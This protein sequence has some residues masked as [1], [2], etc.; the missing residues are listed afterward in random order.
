M[1]ALF[2]TAFSCSRQQKKQCTVS[3]SIFSYLIWESGTSLLLPEKCP[4]RARSVSY[5]ATR[6]RFSILSILYLLSTLLLKTNL[7]IHNKKAM[8][9][10][11]HPFRVEGTRRLQLRSLL[12]KRCLTEIRSTAG[13]STFSVEIAWL[14]FL[15]ILLSSLRCHPSPHLPHAASPAVW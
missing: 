9:L 13:I 3:H 1:A 14:F 6:F 12:L 8:F 4:C 2:T 7:A 11:P 10:V 5:E 15:L